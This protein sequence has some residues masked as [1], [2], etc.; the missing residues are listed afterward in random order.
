MGL[1][2][3]FGDG[4]ATRAIGGVIAALGLLLQGLAIWP[5]RR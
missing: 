4:S 2:G 3:T 5:L 1:F